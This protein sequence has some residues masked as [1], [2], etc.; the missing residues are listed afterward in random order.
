MKKICSSCIQYIKKHPKLD[1]VVLALA[2]ALFL[3]ITLINAPR[4]SIW[5]DEAFSAYITHFSFFDIAKYT[6][7]DVHPPLYYW[8]LKA[9]S[10]IFGATD[11][12]YRSLSIALGAGTIAIAFA[13]ARK[14]FGRQVAWASL[15]LL[16][17]S[18][19]LV[20]YS[21]EARMY[22]LSAL[23]VFL[24]TYVLIKAKE[25]KNRKLWVAYGVL[26]SLGMWTHYFTALAW[27]AHWVWWGVGSYKKGISWKKY[28]KAFFSKEWLLS[29]GLAIALY[30]PWLPFMLRQLGI[31]QVAGFWI[32]PVGVDTPTNYLTN[33]FYYLEHSQVKSWLAL[34][35]IAVV[36]TVV[37]TLPKVV[38][39][40]NEFERRSFSLLTILAWVPFG[41]LFLA[42]LPPLRSSYVER[43]LIPSI[44]AM[45]LF[46][47]VTL[48]VGTRTWKPPLRPLPFILIAGM[49]IFGVT[50][51]YKYGNYNKNSGTHI[52]ARQAVELAQQE[53]A[54]IPIITTSPW[55]FY[56]AAPYA[57]AS[58]PVYFIDAS[59][60]YEYGSLEMLKDNDL[61][62]IKDLGAFEKQHALIWYLGNTSSADVAPY[63][64]Q[65]VKVKTVKPVDP[66]EGESSY[67]ATL[68]KVS[69][70]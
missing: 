55:S 3:T 54:G 40:L 38:R 7:S 49:M 65:W 36:V 52:M 9:W 64:T 70:E 29:Y 58:S 30:L 68:Y 17:I 61:H 27:L 4:A 19:M 32:G 33:Y 69:A 41:L 51:V 67:K 8:L 16:S 47:A 57:T 60:S 1:C 23:I 14:L 63:D 39:R 13:L 45:S 25:T 11:L 66:L 34:A 10:G 28:W 6:A 35:L 53:G 2:L 48:V 18:P 21:D 46:L 15:L 43:Y 26:I 59:T 37:V 24:A 22:T 12:G 5:F 31:V 56:E 42:S 20:R 50:N 44:V 62:K